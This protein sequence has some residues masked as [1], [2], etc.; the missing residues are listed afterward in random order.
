MS[1]ILNGQNN[2]LAEKELLFKED[3]QMTG[4][5]NAYKERF[6]AIPVHESIG[7]KKKANIAGKV[8]FTRSY[9]C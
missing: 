7:L 6:V 1:W 4:I 2:V 3:T 5:K 8:N 9:I